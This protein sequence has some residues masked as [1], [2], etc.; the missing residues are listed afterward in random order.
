MKT[1]TIIILLMNGE[2]G[3]VHMDE[4]RCRHIEREWLVTLEMNHPVTVTM[5]D[6]SQMRIK[7]MWCETETGRRPTS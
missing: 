7:A 3:P 4:K 6:G 2:S 5:E 1:A